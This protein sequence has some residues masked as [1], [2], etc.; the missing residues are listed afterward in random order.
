MLIDWVVMW[1]HIQTKICMSQFSVYFLTQW[2]I[3][4]S[5]NVEIQQKEVAICLILKGELYTVASAGKYS[6]KS[7]GPSALCSNI[8]KLHLW[9]HK[10]EGWNLFKQFMEAS[11][12]ILLSKKAA[13]ILQEQNILALLRSIIGL[14]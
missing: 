3:F 10:L 2:A 6:K 13:G 11:A 4:V 7:L 5:V 14:H 9:E 1:T 12:P 8:N